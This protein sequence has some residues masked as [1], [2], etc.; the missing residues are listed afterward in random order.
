MASTIFLKAEEVKINTAYFFSGL[1][2][3]KG[4]YHDKNLIIN[5]EIKKSVIRHDFYA[6][7]LTSKYFSS[8]N[9]QIKTAA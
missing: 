4:N 1:S 9:P 8:K 6:I 3:I 5:S 2:A 7:S